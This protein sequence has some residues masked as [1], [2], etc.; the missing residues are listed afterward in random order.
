[1]NVLI[2]VAIT[3]IVGMPV[4]LI[5]NLSRAGKTFTSDIPRYEKILSVPF[6]FIIVEAIIIFNLIEWHSDRLKK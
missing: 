4:M 5:W 1:M 2:V 3:W 6:W